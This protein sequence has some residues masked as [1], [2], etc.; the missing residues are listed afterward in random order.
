MVPNAYV[1]NF[2]STIYLL[3]TFKNYLLKLSFFLNKVLKSYSLL[4]VGKPILFHTAK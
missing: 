1:K 4:K 2:Y 3:I